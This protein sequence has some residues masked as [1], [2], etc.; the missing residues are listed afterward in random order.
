V[1]H[2][3]PRPIAQFL[4]AAK[5]MDQEDKK[6]VARIIFGMKDCRKRMNARAA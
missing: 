6:L 5:G 4:K 3:T 1:G 2:Q